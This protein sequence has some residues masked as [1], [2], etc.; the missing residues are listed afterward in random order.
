MCIMCKYNVNRLTPDTR[1]SCKL[2]QNN[3]HAMQNAQKLKER[4]NDHY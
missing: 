3:V 1:Y 4:F 2:K